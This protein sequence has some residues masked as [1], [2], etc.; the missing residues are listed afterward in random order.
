M[1]VCA[2]KPAIRALQAVGVDV[3][4]GTH[5]MK[6]PSWQTTMNYFNAMNMFFE[7]GVPLEAYSNCGLTR[8]LQ[9]LV[10]LVRMQ[11]FVKPM[12]LN[13]DPWP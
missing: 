11:C 13:F 4:E 2:P 10:C 9:I 8:V 6:F 12:T 5:I 1:I 7:V 3:R